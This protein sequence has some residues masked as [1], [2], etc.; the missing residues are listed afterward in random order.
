M[1]TIFDPS[2]AAV[3]KSLVASSSMFTVTSRS[4]D[5][6]ALA[7]TVK[8]AAAP[9]STPDPG[10]MLIVWSIILNVTGVFLPGTAPSAPRPAYMIPLMRII[11]VSAVLS[12]TASAVAMSVITTSFAEAPVFGPVNVTFGDLLA[13]LRFA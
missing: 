13:S 3:T 11:A 9:S 8:D 2:F 6:A 1:V 12:A 10:A 7:R 4:D 5:G